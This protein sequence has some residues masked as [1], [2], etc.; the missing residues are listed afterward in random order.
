[1]D[2]AL[3][4]LRRFWEFVQFLVRHF[5]EDSC[6][7]TAAALTYQTLFAV[8]P[9]LTVVYTVISAFDAFH[10][11]GVEVENFIF[12]NVVPENVATVQ[13]YIHSFSDQARNL[14]IPSGVFLAV[15]VFTMLFTIE[16]TFN[17]I[18]RIKEPRRGFDRLLMYWAVLTLWPLLV[19]ASSSSRK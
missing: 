14:S 4:Y 2:V 8:V 19:S 7:S 17:E 13:E 11:M 16:R 6:Q 18:W 12:N 1:M 5:I 10:G 3:G 15:T 9:L